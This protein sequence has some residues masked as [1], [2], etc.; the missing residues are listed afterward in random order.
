[1]QHSF[2]DVAI[3]KL[4]GL[5]NQVKNKVT[6]YKSF[7]TSFTKDLPESDAKLLEETI[8]DIDQVTAEDLVSVLSTFLPVEEV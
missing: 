6:S 8:P 2:S 3:P 1:M 4:K 5:I 7:Y